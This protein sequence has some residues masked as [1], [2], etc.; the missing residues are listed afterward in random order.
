MRKI[1]ILFLLVAYTGMGQSITDTIQLMHYNLLNYRNLTSYCTVSNNNPSDKDEHMSTIIGYLLPDIVTV[2]EMV[3]DGGTG[4]NRLLTNAL[5]QDGRKFYKQASYSANS[6]LCNMLYYNKNKFELHRQDK[7]DRAL[8]KTQLVRQI[9]VYD[10]YYKD[11]SQ[12]ELGDTQFL[13]VFVGHLKAG[14]STSDVSERAKATEAVM[15]Y[16][17]SHYSSR[18]SY[19]FSGDFNT[20]T[21]NELGF[22]NLVGNSNTSI[23]FK[24]PIKSSGTWNNNSAFASVHTQSTHSSGPCFVG[25]GLDDRFDFILCG[26]E[27]LSNQRGYGYVNG[28][29][30]ALGN[31]GNHFNS[32]IITG[33]NNS[34]SATVLNA[35]YKM[36][37][38]LPVIMQLKTNRTI[39]GIFSDRFNNFL[40]TNNPV[41]DVLYWKSK[42]PYQGQLEI[43][44]MQGQVV[45]SQYVDTK[46]S[47]NQLDVSALANGMFRLIFRVNG[48]PLAQKKVIKIPH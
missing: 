31:D 18:Y 25:G 44:N 30:Q 12:L 38:H 22:I 15:D 37:D 1:T 32:N 4:A 40:V 45:L 3:G 17:A 20:Y 48:Y 33:T 11:Q 24:D 29:Y 36:S 35:L 28:S 6:S 2:N 21:S 13:R 26:Q 42:F 16:H 39:V 10:L 47:W 27:I 5:N 41:K 23:R 8:N 14:N 46:T 9:D 43:A 34:V 7:I 19:L